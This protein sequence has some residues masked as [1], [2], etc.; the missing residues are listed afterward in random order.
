AK[1]TDRGG[2][3]RLTAERQ[4]SDAVV[5]VRDSGLG[6]PREMLGK[7][8]ELFTQVD[9]TLEKAQGGL[10][11]GLT[12]VRRLTEMHGGSVEAHSEGYGHG[13]EF[14]V[15]LPALQVASLRD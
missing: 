3:I 5:S 2:K 7:I 12:L 13:S 6:I 15:R 1:Y 10:G 14:V 11:I 4:G 9:R 8:F